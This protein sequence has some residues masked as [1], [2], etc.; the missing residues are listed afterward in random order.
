M[1]A[2]SAPSVAQWSAVLRQCQAGAAVH[3]DAA[4]AELLRWTLHPDMADAA[5]GLL[6]LTADREVGEGVGFPGAKGCAFAL[7]VSQSFALSLRR[8]DPSVHHQLEP[9]HPCLSLSL[10]RSC[11]CE[12][13]GL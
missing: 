5:A 2:L 7:R 11:I 8:S 12:L 4:A 10:Y 13:F 6:S 1:Q 3:C 9:A